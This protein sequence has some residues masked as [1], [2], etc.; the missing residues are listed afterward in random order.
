[1]VVSFIEL[2]MG[3]G[4][5]RSLGRVN[6]KFTETSIWKCFGSNRKCKSKC[7][8]A[9]KC[10]SLEHREGNTSHGAQWESWLECEKKRPLESSPGSDN[11]GLCGGEAANTGDW[12]RV[13]RMFWVGEK[14]RRKMESWGLREEL[15]KR[16]EKSVVSF[17]FETSS[18]GR[19]G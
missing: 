17:A 14:N 2:G 18:N 16:K 1:M 9:G 3:E 19:Y 5:R 13:A 11:W 10:G 8:W 4:G 7:K 15:H 6:S 12:E